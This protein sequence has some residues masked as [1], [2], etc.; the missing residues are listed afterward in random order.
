MTYF[1]E[2]LN[3]MIAALNVVYFAFGSIEVQNVSEFQNAYDMCVYI[4]IYMFINV[5]LYVYVYVYIY[6]YIHNV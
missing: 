5:Y 6:I 4:Y 3:T 1:S 2:Y